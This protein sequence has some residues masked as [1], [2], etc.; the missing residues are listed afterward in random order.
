MDSTD[1]MAGP[2]HMEE[3]VPHASGLSAALAA[4]P[5]VVLSASAAHATVISRNPW[6]RGCHPSLLLVAEI[7][8]QGAH[9][10]DRD[11]VMQ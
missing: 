1:R 6:G 3:I 9:D 11:A 8:T 10:L 4:T 5:V 7:V 2:S